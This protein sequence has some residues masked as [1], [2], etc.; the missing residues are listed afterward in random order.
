MEGIES[1]K[2]GVI[3]SGLAGLFLALE[4]WERGAVP[5]IFCDKTNP[6]GASI[7]AQGVVS[8]K[9]LTKPE[10]PLFKLKLL[11]QRFL[12][13]RLNYFST[14]GLKYSATRGVMEAY[15]D[16]AEYR[17]ICRRVYRERYRGLYL[18]ESINHYSGSH[19]PESV[20]FLR[21]RGDFWLDVPYLLQQIK[22]F[23]INNGVKFYHARVK[24]IKIGASIS[25]D[26]SIGGFLFDSCVVASGASSDGLIPEVKLRSSL[27]KVGGSSLELP[28]DFKV[29]SFV[30]GAYS[31]H[32]S[33]KFARIGS[34]T[35]KG[36]F[37]GKEKQCLE[38]LATVGR[39]RFSIPKSLIE[40][41][42]LISGNRCV[43]FDRKPLVGGF[44]DGR[45]NIYILS[46]FHKSGLALAPISAYHLAD[47]IAFG[48]ESYLL[49]YCDPNYK[50]KTNT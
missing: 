30:S 8:T 15:K 1:E 16:P 24:D 35:I 4:L 50:A 44:D 14:K 45:Q 33:G 32:F 7:A 48:K 18:T 25:I 34:T 29:S 39:D 13:D 5:V 49:E 38:S 42:R 31:A 36:D 46:G 22:V 40:N 37:R 19:F 11:G 27:K 2:I 12:L 28:C 20:N 6:F 9:G 23:L 43:T 21:Y 47:K 41:G 26:S 17:D 3:G 10:H